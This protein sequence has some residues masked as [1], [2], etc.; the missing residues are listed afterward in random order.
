M[1]Y[2]LE[3]AV[4]E[5]V[6][7]FCLPQDHLS[8]VAVFCVHVGLLHVTIA[9]AA[10]RKY[11]PLNVPLAE[12]GYPVHRR[13]PC[14]LGRHHCW[15]CHQLECVPQQLAGLNAARFYVECWPYNAMQT[16]WGAP[17]QYSV[18][19]QSTAFVFAVIFA[20]LYTLLPNHPGSVTHVD[21]TCF[22]ALINMRFRQDS[23]LCCVL[24]PILLH[25]RR[26]SK[27]VAARR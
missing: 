11:F 15:H 4:S 12:H 20:W 25:S 14:R 26:R 3:R 23:I 17:T 13:S 2:L 16:F 18:Q 7:H 5:Y 27:L 21:L 10:Q 9:S 24:R 22:A 19:Y 1:S 8:T 6:L